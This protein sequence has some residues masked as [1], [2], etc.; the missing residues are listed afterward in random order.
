MTY[1]AIIWGLPLSLIIF[2]TFKETSKYEEI[3]NNKVQQNQEPNINLFKSNLKIIFTSGHRNEFITILIISVLVG[4]NY[5]F[6]S[7]GESYISSSPNLNAN[8]INII[9][10]VMSVSVVF[11]YLFT[12]IVADK[13]GRKP[14]FYIYSFLIPVS[15]LLVIFGSNLTEGALII[16]CIGAGL[17]NITYWGLGVIIRLITIEI[18][19]TRARGT[20]S[21]LKSLVQ[22]MGITLGLLLSSL[23]TFFYG[24]AASFII[25]CLLLFMNLPLIYF[26]IK[27]TK[28]LDLSEI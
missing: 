12:G 16:V 13:F 27:E 15:I 5:I 1:F 25:I 20:G 18:L 26:F 14:L 19:P 17:A 3:K 6:V 28:G 9:V 11:G 22:A 2:L 24:L 4:M 8:D 21:G 7:V 23:I 10:L